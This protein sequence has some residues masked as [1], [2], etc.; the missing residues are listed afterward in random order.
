MLTPT[1]ARQD[2]ESA[3]RELRRIATAAAAD[4]D[5]RAAA[6]DALD[7]VTLRYLNQLTLEIGALTGQYRAFLTEMGGLVKRLGAGTPLDG[8]KKLSG[9]VAAGNALLARGASLLGG[10]VRAFGR[11]GRKT[12]SLAAPAGDRTLRILCVH[13]VGHQ[14][15]DPTFEAS[16]K[17]AITAGLAE[18][19]HDR[20]FQVEFVAYDDLFAANPPGVLDVAQAV[21][22]LTVSGLIHGIGDLFRRRRGFG[23]IKESVRW[24]AGMVVQWAEDG[25][26]RAASRRRVLEHTRRFDPHVILAHSLGTLLSY[27]AF[28]R[29]EGRALIAGRTFVSFGSQ[30]GNPFVRTTL[31]GR[32][33]P[34][35]DARRWFHLF[36]PHDDAFTAKLRLSAGNF[37]QVI[38]EFDLDGILDHDAPAYLRHPN[39]LNT[40]WRSVATAPAAA[41]GM[42]GD[43]PSTALTLAAREKSPR[44]TKPA[45]PARRALLVG[46]NDYPNPSDRLEGCVNDVFL[47]SSL[48]QESGFAADDI[49][50]VLN[51]RATA[52]G[53]VERLEWLLEGTADGQQ[54]VFY[55]SGHGAQIPGDGYGETVDSKDECLVAHD[56]DWSRDHAVTDDQFHDL[57]SQLPY[58]T[59]FLTIL[60]CCHSGG[61]TREGS[62]RVRGLTPPDDIR[63]RELKWDTGHQMW[64]QRDFAAEQKL[65]AERTRKPALFGED[66]DLSRLGRSA[67]LRTDQR[68][69]KQA[70]RDYGHKG[71]FMPVIIQACQEKQ[72][73]YEYRHGVQ[74]Y[75]AFTYSLGLALRGLR[76]R[77]KMPTWAGLVQALTTKLHALQYDQTPVLVCPTSLRKQPVPWGRK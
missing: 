14:E 77:Q 25:D 37:E 64:V 33:E 30:I 63:H 5:Q 67:G 55:Y 66:G 24:T 29:A 28:A 3:M 16:W 53:I 8:I 43:L 73:S 75:G 48:L 47:M 12:R 74:S 58:G 44:R 36:N 35:A 72:Y 54:R 1:L 13:G 21:A 68:G 76:P 65:V 9:L 15:A 42:P 50:V 10:G 34:L 6:L 18:W 56:F 17:D 11:P 59:Q 4:D 69:F 60:D 57:Y 45:K 19:T 39:T 20:A 2:Y 70:C 7:Q 71:P 49:R 51:D 31:G 26:L 61:M 23:D 32:I 62:S 41:R 27:D 40:V 38:A 52:R 46:I 22:K